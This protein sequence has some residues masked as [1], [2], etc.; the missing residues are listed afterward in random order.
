MVSQR[1]RTIKRPA[2][3]WGGAKGQNGY[4][5]PFLHQNQTKLNN[6]TT[7]LTHFAAELQVAIE[8]NGGATKEPTV[9]QR[10]LK[11][12]PNLVLSR[13]KHLRRRIKTKEKPNQHMKTMISRR[14]FTLTTHKSHKWKKP[15]H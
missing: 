4:T 1:E 14:K 15:K 10:H 6:M 3:G 2:G 12:K 8:K 5:D 9:K 11:Q 7:A 13:K